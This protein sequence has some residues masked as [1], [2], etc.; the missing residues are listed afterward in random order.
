MMLWPIGI[1]NQAITRNSP[2]PVTN[3]CYTAAGPVTEMVFYEIAAWV[4][5]G[6]TS[7]GSIEVGGIALNTVLDHTT[8][9][10]PRFACEVA[11]AAAGMSR[12]EA[13]RICKALNDKY[14]KNLTQPPTGKN[15]RE[16]F[17]VQTSTPTEEYRKFYKDMKAKI[18]DL[19]I[20]LD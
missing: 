10:E 11:H 18:K 3:L 7:G 15:Y 6:V 9:C 14:E 4:L 19:G 12:K 16:C 20:P 17:D 1:A 8:P 13:N 5:T 2:V